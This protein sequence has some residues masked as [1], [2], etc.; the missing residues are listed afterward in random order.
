MGFLFALQFLVPVAVGAYIVWRFVLTPFFERRLEQE[1]REAT[2]QKI[3]EKL[4]E[5]D[6]KSPAS[7]QADLS[8]EEIDQAIEE[9]NENN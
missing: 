5:A 6:S 1:E 3:R 9:L 2:S 4:H 8:D 7:K